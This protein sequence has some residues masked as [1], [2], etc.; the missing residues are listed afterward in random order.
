M[1]IK[2]TIFIIISFSITTSYGRII[3]IA[4]HERRASGDKYTLFEFLIPI[5]YIAFSC[6]VPTLWGI[7]LLMSI[8]KMVR[9]F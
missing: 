6:I 1:Y 2:T 3:S 7:F 9:E 4:L 8:K 5:M